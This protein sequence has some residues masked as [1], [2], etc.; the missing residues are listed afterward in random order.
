MDTALVAETKGHVDHMREIVKDVHESLRGQTN[1]TYNFHNSSFDPLRLGGNTL[2][3]LYRDLM[4][5]WL[6][7]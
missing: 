6:I 3:S 7:S 2:T 5:D 4:Q 1:L